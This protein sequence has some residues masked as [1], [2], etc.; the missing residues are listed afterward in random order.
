[1][2]SR[3]VLNALLPEG[4]FWTPATGGD[5]D[6]LL[7]GVASNTE[8]IR[9]NLDNLRRLRDPSSTPVLSDLEKEYGVL[10]GP[11]S[12][13]SQRRSRLQAFMFRRG[14]LPTYEFLEERLRSAGFTQA[15]VHANSPAVD[16]AI[17]LAQAFNMVCDDLLP[18]GNDPQC[19]EPEAICASVGGELLVNGEIFI[20]EPNYTVLCDEALAQCGEPDAVAGDFDGVN[21]IPIDYEIPVI[22]G[23]W[24]LIFF[25]GGQAT[26]DPVTG[27]I[28]DIESITIPL[29]RRLEFRRIIL[30][31]KPMHSW[32]ALVVNYG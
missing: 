27:A 14:E 18:G 13:V 6:N 30:T 20:Q 26:R 10:P 31:Y 8:I 2:F 9:L 5:Y 11:G 21:L 15:Y 7:E 32:G 24:P 3:S 17:F 23:Y 16:P 25:V 29:A 1:M 22:A 4:A 19:G 28:T 12:T